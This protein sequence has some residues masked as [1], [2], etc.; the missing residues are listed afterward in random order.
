MG[1]VVCVLGKTVS[2]MVCC[3]HTSPL[4]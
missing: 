2:A 1:E 3:S 4:F